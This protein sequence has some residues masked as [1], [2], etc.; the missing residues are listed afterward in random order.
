MKRR[1]QRMKKRMRIVI[2][3]ITLCI[4]SLGHAQ[5]LFQA[6]GNITL[7]F[8]KGEFDENI[9]TIGIGATGFFA[10]NFP[11]SPLS[12]GA[13]LG[14]LIYGRETEERPFSM[15][16]PDV[17]VDVT[18]TNSILQ[19]HLLLRLQPP[20]GALLPYLDGLVGFNYLWTETSI[21]DQDTPGY[22]EIASTTQLDDI[23][24]SYGVGG[25]LMFRVYQGSI[26]EGADHKLAAIYVD[27]GMRY[28]MG[29]E[30]EYLKEG[31]I[32]IENGQVYYDI[33]KS[34]TDILTAHIGV[35]FAF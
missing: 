29:G 15:T 3:L 5:M 18:T 6:G 32:Q 7:G 1:T 14:F 9:E 10:V 35:S 23:T 2:A 20:K 8:P 25:G 31:S 19:G 24:F 13:S 28:L 22:D 21:E 33:S 11:Q 17:Y 4:V 34:T 27:L 30:A 16:I 12:V 26:Q